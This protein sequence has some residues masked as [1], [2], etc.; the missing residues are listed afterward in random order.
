MATIYQSFQINAPIDR[1]FKAISTPKG[2]A[3]WWSVKS[4]GKPYLGEEYS[5]YFSDE[6]DWKGSLVQFVENQAIEWEMTSADVD[7]TGTAL[8]FKLSEGDNVVNVAFEHSGWKEV[9]DHFKIS[10]YCWAQYMR[11]L[12]RYCELGEIVPY[13]NR[14]GS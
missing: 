12:K 7:W 4:G 3:I 10:T 13:E 1:V 5:F 2:I 9:N 11:T 8:R 14:G 6:Y